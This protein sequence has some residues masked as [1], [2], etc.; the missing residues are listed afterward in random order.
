ME[1]AYAEASKTTWDMNCFWGTYRTS[2]FWTSA[3]CWCTFH[4]ALHSTMHF[5]FVRM[6]VNKS[7]GANLW[8]QEVIRLWPIEEHLHSQQHSIRIRYLL[9]RGVR[10]QQWWDFSTRAQCV[11]Y[12]S[13]ENIMSSHRH[14]KATVSIDLRWQSQPL[15]LHH[16]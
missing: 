5:L 8:L 11:S 16:C 12:H 7:K 1:A 9:W 3:K 14:A 15:R 6:F 4:E 13:S 10:N 2:F